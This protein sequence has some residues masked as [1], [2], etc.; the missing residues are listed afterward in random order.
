ME[1]SVKSS[2]QHIMLKTSGRGRLDVEG[3]VVEEEEDR[4]EEGREGRRRTRT[5]STNLSPL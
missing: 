2:E 5:S 1:E 4:E 3:E